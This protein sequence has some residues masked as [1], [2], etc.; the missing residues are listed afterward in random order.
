MYSSAS[1]AALKSSETAGRLKPSASTHSISG[2]STAMERDSS[3]KR[4]TTSSSSKPSRSPRSARNG[5]AAAGA[6]LAAS[7][8]SVPPTGTTQPVSSSMPASSSNHSID[9]NDGKP[10]RRTRSSDI[11]EVPIRPGT[12][13]SP[14]RPSSSIESI[15]GNA[16]SGSSVP[17]A[18]GGSTQTA[19]FGS[20]T[21]NSVSGSSVASSGNSTARVFQEG[22]LLK[23]NKQGRWKKRWIVVKLTNFEIYKTK[24]DGDKD[25]KKKVV[26][27]EH[28]MAKEVYNAENAFEVLARDGH[29]YVFSTG[30]SAVDKL[31]W[32][33]TF[34]TRT[35]QLITEAL[36]KSIQDATAGGGGSGGDG[37][38]SSAS[39]SS[40]GTRAK[41]KQPMSVD[42][43]N[44]LL[45][46]GNS[47]C[48]DCGA[49]DPEWASVT[50]G[51]FVCIDCSGVHRSLSRDVSTIR[52]ISLD[53]WDSDAVK[54]MQGMGNSKSNSFWEANVP[55]SAE[56]MRIEPRSTQE[57]RKQWIT[58][59]YLLHSFVASGTQLSDIDAFLPP[60]PSSQTY[61]WTQRVAMYLAMQ[62]AASEAAAVGAASSASSMVTS[63]A[64]SYSGGMD[65]KSKRATIN[66]SALIPGSL[67]VDREKK[68]EKKRLKEI[69]EANE[70]RTS[71]QSQ[72]LQLLKSPNL[73]KEALVSLLEEDPSFRHQ[74]RSLL[75][76]TAAE[77]E[78]MT[79]GNSGAS[80]ATSS[81][82]NTS[83]SSS[84]SAAT[85]A[86][87]A[88]A[89]ATTTIATSSASSTSPSP[90]P[91]HVSH[92]NPLTSSI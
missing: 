82:N 47:M 68:K 22:Y 76:A 21:F 2:S 77:D 38:F 14:I 88:A 49:S 60:N 6:S 16:T 26:S 86:A 11:E 15:H 40:D 71:E 85:A 48:A 39:G 36:D 4:N 87:A 74:L 91:N 79:T 31:S 50:L 61:T 80:H 43:L 34:R 92:T 5:D 37:T 8:S 33:T 66:F 59:K 72:L 41:L 27:L 46:D 45:E 81:N 73:L 30:D 57:Q 12:G 84:N 3:P 62:K 10:H 53:V 90:A 28:S 7:A 32:F 13:S 67:M 78:M 65:K 24:P 23:R 17:N 29:H 69:E 52:S 64:S 1:S 56:M 20:S 44:L 54:A 89:A 19:G 42:I 25:A 18:G 63:S 75:L 70:K 9:S 83:N 58:Q 51:I 55:D 35:E